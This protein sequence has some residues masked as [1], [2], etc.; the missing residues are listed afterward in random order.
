MAP[1]T[2]LPGLYFTVNKAGRFRMVNKG[3][4][5]TTAELPEHVKLPDALIK[6]TGSFRLITSGWVASPAGLPDHVTPI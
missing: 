4:M 2:G 1:P 5:G 6:S 3:W